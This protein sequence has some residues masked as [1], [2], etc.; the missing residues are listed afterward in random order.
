MNKFKLFIENFLVYGL[1]GII[2]KLIPLIMVP[3]VTRLMPNTEYY[4]ISDLSNTVVQFGSAIAVIG[5]Y[6]AMYRMFFEKEDE[7]LRLIDGN[8]FVCSQWG[9]L[10]ISNFIKRAEQLGYEIEQ[11]VRE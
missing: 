10:N 5:M 7:I 9:V 4:G 2:S 8:M 1:G 11:I 6:D 3:I